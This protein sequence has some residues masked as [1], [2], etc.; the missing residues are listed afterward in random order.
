MS[1]LV[2]V[3]GPAKPPAVPCENERHLTVPEAV[4]V[5]R[6]V[7]LPDAEGYHVCADCLTRYVQDV[8]LD[9]RNDL[10]LAFVV[11]PC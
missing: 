7:D 9:K 3:F 5:I 8:C 4:A 10:R 2:R 11:E 1:N 6:L